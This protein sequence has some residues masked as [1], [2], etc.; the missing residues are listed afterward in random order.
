MTLHDCDDGG[1]VVAADIV[2]PDDPTDYQSGA[3]ILGCSRLRCDRCGS[4]VRQLAGFDCPNLQAHLKRLDETPDWTTLDIV[5]PFSPGRLYACRCLGWLES[6]YHACGD[7]EPD[8]SAGDP[9]LPWRCAGHPVATLPV[10]VDGEVIDADTDLAALV[11]RIL[12]GWSPDIAPPPSPWSPAAWLYRVRR[13]LAD[14]P[15]ARALAEAVAAC[16]DDPV[17][18]AGAIAYYCGFPRDPGFARVLALAAEPGALFLRTPNVVEDGDPMEYWPAWA[19]RCRLFSVRGKLD[20]L[21]RKALALMQAAL[22]RGD[23]GL[24]PEDIDGV[25]C[26]AGPWLAQQAGAIARADPSR[27]IAILQSLK[28]L[29]DPGLVA[30][31]GVALA[32]EPGSDHAALHEWLADWPNRHEPYAGPIEVALERAGR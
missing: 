28:D 13:R 4:V 14:L 7:P 22:L 29:D 32:A 18:R 30:I 21:D 16:L 9:S 8:A 20:S 25:R 6:S 19:L 26:V 12:G 17:R 27:T 10:T 24:E 3:A 1:Y 15:I 2:V 23:A 31:A 5:R 11:A